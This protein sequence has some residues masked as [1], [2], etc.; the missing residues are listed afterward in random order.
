[1]GTVRDIL[2]VKGHAVYSVQPD[3]TVFDALS[4]LVDKNVGALVVL[5][6]NEK[7]LGI[8]SERDYARRVILKGRASK[9]TLIREI[10]TE[11]PF[12]VTEEDSIQDCMVKMTDKHIRHLPV[13]DDQL[14]LVG[15]ISIGDVVK[16]VI[17]EQRY[18]ID[19]LEGY[20][21]GTR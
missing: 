5:G 17:D 4:V 16:Y 7:V 18:I 11:H 21:K 3:D 1:M 19:N 13:T 2:R 15:M 8:F 10:M 20:I 14:R 12:T 6:D 9:E